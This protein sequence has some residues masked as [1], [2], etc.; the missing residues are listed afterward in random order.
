MPF[1]KLEIKLS[2]FM[3]LPIRFVAQLTKSR[4]FNIN[5]LVEL[6]QREAACNHG[7]CGMFGDYQ[8]V[9]DR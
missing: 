3:M 8:N 4:F 1:S 7:V 6:T 2:S 5:L 9:G